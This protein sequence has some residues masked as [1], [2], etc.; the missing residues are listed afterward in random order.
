MRV[1]MIDNYDSFTFNLVQYLQEL[2]ID[3]HTLRNDQSSVAEVLS[4]K[5]DF[6]MLSPGPSTPD[7]AGI[8]LDLV[9][10]A[11][12]AALPV[13]G[14]CLGHQAIGQAFGASVVNAADCMHGKTS[15]IHHEGKGVF[16]GLPSPFTA[17]RYH[18]LIIDPD[19]LP[20]ELEVT[21]RTADG[22]IM[23]VGHRTL[24]IVGIQF[25]PESV[26]SEHG[27]Q[28]LKNFADSI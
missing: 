19:T 21:A 4:E 7:H 22:V 8:C 14:I 6:Y 25:H 17:T 10:Q 5:P 13:L 20:N 18:S 9:K 15:L 26:L 16:S 11:S 3:V 23:A 2:E 27:H 28:L 12:A 24:P 1:V